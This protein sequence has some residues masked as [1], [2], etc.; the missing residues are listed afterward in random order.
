VG[1]AALGCAASGAP[2]PAAP[3]PGPALRTSDAAYVVRGRPSRYEAEIPVTYTNRTRDTVWLR[4]CSH[5]LEQRAG[6][7][8]GAWRGVYAPVCPAI[9]FTH[10]PVAPG[11]TRTWTLSVHAFRD[12][13][14]AVPRFRGALPGTYRLTLGV[15][16]DAAAVDPAGLRPLAERVS[17]AFRLT[18]PPASGAP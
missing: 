15:Y 4:G 9:A 13:P 10:T 5:V 17:N 11:A 12:R 2:A 14:R 8:P 16:G 7:D 6:G 1:L 18:E 3:T